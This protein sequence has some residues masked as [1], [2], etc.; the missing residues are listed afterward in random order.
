MRISARNRGTAR[1]EAAPCVLSVLILV[2]LSI[3]YYNRMEKEK[4]NSSRGL[5][6]IW[7]TL[8]NT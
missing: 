8:N 2:L 1:L 4:T 3:M 5:E 7:Q 6:H